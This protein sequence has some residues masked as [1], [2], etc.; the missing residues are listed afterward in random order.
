MLIKGVI[1]EF[2]LIAVG[3]DTLGWLGLRAERAFQLPV[4]CV[5]YA[6]I[7]CVH[8]NDDNELW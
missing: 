4:Q 6:I 3:I 1:G 5:V 8:P 7:L 2:L